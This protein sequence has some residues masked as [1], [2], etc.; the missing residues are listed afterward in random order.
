M[1][2]E[3]RTAIDEAIRE[4][5]EAGHNGRYHVCQAMP[6]D[7]VACAACVCSQT[8][9]RL[10]IALARHDVLGPLLDTIRQA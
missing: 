8:Y 9:V 5:R 3:L 2:D 4:L 7:V 1:T 10:V 6:P